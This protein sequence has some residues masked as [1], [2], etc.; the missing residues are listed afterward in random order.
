MLLVHNSFFISLTAAARYHLPLS[1]V[2]RAPAVLVG[3]II[4]RYHLHQSRVLLEKDALIGWPSRE[5][6]RSWGWETDVSFE[7]FIT[8]LFIYMV[9]YER[10]IQQ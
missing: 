10:L 8:T 6:S 2:Q 3:K 1:V 5:R 7:G 9:Y 4:P